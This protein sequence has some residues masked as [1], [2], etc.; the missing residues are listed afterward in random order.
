[1]AN[2]FCPS[3]G[4]AI[5]DPAWRFCPSCGGRLGTAGQGCPPIPPVY[6]HGV[7]PVL[8]IAAGVF[9]VIAGVA[10]FL[11][12]VPLSPVPLHAAADAGTIV[13]SAAPDLTGAPGNVTTPVQPPPLLNS[14][15]NTSGP[16]PRVNATTVTPTRSPIS[17][18]TG[19]VITITGTSPYSYQAPVMGSSPE[20]PVINTTSLAARVHALVNKARQENGRSVLG[21]DARLAAIARAHS[22]DMAAH[23]YFGHVNLQE[24]DPTARGA[25]AGY[26]CQK[27]FDS[28][29][30]YGIA[31]NLFATYRYNSVLFIDKKAIDYDWST[32]EEIAE[33]TVEAWMNSPDHRDNL[34]D[35][36]MVR[37]GIGVAISD[38]DLVF[39]TEDFC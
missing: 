28:Y 36:G 33:E 11:Q 1:M 37:E 39:V 9:L 3:C 32:E 2:S 22:E 24:K 34:L 26:T 17:Q 12:A 25:A 27:A 18:F 15:V 19:P 5:P 10:A 23:G 20:V 31:E 35:P 13:R 16:G 7:I 6:S 4:T 38:A 14:T 29:Y 8:V 21:T 30:T